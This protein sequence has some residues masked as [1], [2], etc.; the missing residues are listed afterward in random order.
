[1]LDDLD[2]CD[3]RRETWG[4]GPSSNP[5]SPCSHTELGSSIAGSPTIASGNSSIAGSKPSPQSTIPSLNLDTFFLTSYKKYLPNEHQ[6]MFMKQQIALLCLGVAVLSV[7]CVGSSA[8]ETPRSENTPPTPSNWTSEDFPNIPSETTLTLTIGKERDLGDR[9][10]PHT[11]RIGNTHSESRTIS[12]TVWRDSIVVVN[13]SITLRP[14]S[15]ARITAFRSGSYTL[16][17]DLKNASRHVINDPG[18]WDCNRLDL[19]VELK[20]DGEIVSTWMQTAMGC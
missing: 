15:S 14:N 20:P 12:L 11:Y 18:E 6:F 10:A 4:N 7:G 13:R 19:M 2:L 5:G 9:F 17:I 1:V 8:L 16:V 3:L